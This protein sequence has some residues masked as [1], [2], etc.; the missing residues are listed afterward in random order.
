MDKQD[1]TELIQEVPDS[2][3]FLHQVQRLSSQYT[4]WRAVPADGNCFYRAVAFALLEELLSPQTLLEPL[5]LLYKRLRWQELPLSDERI[6]DYFVVMLVLQALIEKKRDGKADFEGHLAYLM[7][8]KSFAK[9]LIQTLRHMTYQSIL[10]FKPAGIFYPG[11]AQDLSEDL[12]FGHSS[13]EVDLI[14]LSTALDINITQVTMGRSDRSETVK[15]FIS[16]RKETKADITVH[17]GLIGGRFY[18][19]YPKKPV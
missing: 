1:F 8:K 4:G 16:R 2:A 3:N 14:G 6:E 11:C 18:A 19:L 7:R 10:F 9:P 17:V 12:Q 15:E 13:S 5:E